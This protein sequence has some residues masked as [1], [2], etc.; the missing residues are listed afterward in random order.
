MGNFSYSA[1][2]RYAQA[3]VGGV[4]SVN[5]G[6]IAIG[7]R[8]MRC[9]YS[10]ESFAGLKPAGQKDLEAGKCTACGAI[11]IA[12]IFADSAYLPAIA[13]SARSKF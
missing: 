11:G 7:Y 10:R 8:C 6:P 1:P 3:E 5:S 12:L 4:N 2:R 9:N 13:E